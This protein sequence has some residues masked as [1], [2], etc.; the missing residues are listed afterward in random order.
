ME[1]GDI[2]D[3]QVTASSFKN[4][5]RQPFSARLHNRLVDWKP[6]SNSGG[7]WLQIDFIDGVAV[8]KVAT[9]GGVFGGNNWVTS[10][11]LSFS[12]DAVSWEF[13]DENG[14]DKVRTHEVQQYGR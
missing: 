12:R 2:K 14:Q 13:F 8:K 7:E 5:N 3:S 10:Y 1:S 6:G 11:K 9:Q 4:D